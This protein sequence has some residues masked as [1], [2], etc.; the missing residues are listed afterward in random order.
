MA[1]GTVATPVQEVV[2][3]SARLDQ[4]QAAIDEAHLILSD[5]VP[6]DQDENKGAEMGAEALLDHCQHDVQEL[7]TRLID[8][9]N[10]VGAL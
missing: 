1:S 8:I 2:S 9:R 3:L 4:L 5:I 10:R 6:R 7:I